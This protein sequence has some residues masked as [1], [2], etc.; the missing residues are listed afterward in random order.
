MRSVAHAH[1][2]AEPVMS[3]NFV[4]TTGVLYW[5]SWD[6]PNKGDGMVPYTRRCHESRLDLGSM[7]IPVEYIDPKDNMQ[8]VDEIIDSFA[9]KIQIEDT[10]P[11]TEEINCMFVILTPK[12][13]RR[14]DLAPIVLLKAKAVN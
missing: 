2:G 13:T 3:S 10:E 11:S 6:P 1:A 9:S 4:P 7:P 14:T 12:R 8:F 5:Q